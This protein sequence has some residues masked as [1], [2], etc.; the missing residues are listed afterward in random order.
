M[1]SI[2]AMP[3]I[4]TY[5]LLI[6]LAWVS[7]LVAD[8]LLGRLETAP[9]AKSGTLV[10]FGT[11]LFLVVERLI[12]LRSSPSSGVPSAVPNVMVLVTAGFGLAHAIGTLTSRRVQTPQA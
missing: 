12:P 6:D 10:I 1:N 8:F 5:S 9:S 7:A 4:A 3:G 11:T 2:F